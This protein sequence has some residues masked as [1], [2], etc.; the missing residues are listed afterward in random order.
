MVGSIGGAEGSGLSVTIQ[1]DRLLMR[2]ITARKQPRAF[3]L[4]IMQDSIK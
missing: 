3:I 2:K 4:F 1:L